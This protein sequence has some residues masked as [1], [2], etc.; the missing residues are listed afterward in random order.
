M[1]GNSLFLGWIFF[2]LVGI[3]PWLRYFGLVFWIDFSV[4]C[5]K[6]LDIAF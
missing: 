5:F 6:R 1:F 4:T 2:Y 3:Y